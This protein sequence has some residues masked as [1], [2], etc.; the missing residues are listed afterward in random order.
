[1]DIGTSIIVLVINDR[2]EFSRDD[3]DHAERSGEKKTERKQAYLSPLSF[4]HLRS[5]ARNQNLISPRLPPA[6]SKD[7]F[8]RFRLATRARGMNFG[9]VSARADGEGGWWR[10]GTGGTETGTG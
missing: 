1:M 6:P 3:I 10:L 5:T 7:G 2:V 4:S 8:R 9:L